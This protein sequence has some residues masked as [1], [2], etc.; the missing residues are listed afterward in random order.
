[1][2]QLVDQTVFVEPA[3]MDGPRPLGVGL[4]MRYVGVADHGHMGHPRVRRVIGFR[5]IISAVRPK[6][7][8]PLITR[9]CGAE[10]HDGAA[11]CG[12]PTEQ[13]FH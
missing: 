3:E 6:Q 9:Q 5:K 7:L 10:E 4:D 2:P 12:E 13:P 8:Q 11:E 1:M